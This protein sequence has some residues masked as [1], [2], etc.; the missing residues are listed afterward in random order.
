MG[1]SRPQIRSGHFG[2]Q[3]NTLPLSGFELLKG[4]T[5]YWKSILKILDMKVLI[6]SVEDD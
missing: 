5:Q 6:K 3:K 4:F 1:L 2:E